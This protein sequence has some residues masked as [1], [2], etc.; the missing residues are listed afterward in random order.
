MKPLNSQERMKQFFIFLGFFIV[1]SVLIVVVTYYDFSN[2]KEHNRLLLEE[3]ANLKKQL[4]MNE[5]YIS[6]ADSVLSKITLLNIKEPSGMET[7]YSFANQTN[8]TF[9]IMVESDSLLKNGIY[10]RFTLMT[11]TFLDLY[12][13]YMQAKPKANEFDVTKLQ[14]DKL[15]REN[16]DLQKDLIECQ[17]KKPADAL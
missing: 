1:T 3:N 14:N 9:R 4:E 16:K 2:P 13:Q 8:A 17:K 5:K 7:K 6:Q 11:T 15:E 12:S 10:S